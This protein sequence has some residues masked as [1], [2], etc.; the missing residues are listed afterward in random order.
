MEPVV[1]AEGLRHRYRRR[2]ALAATTLD[3]PA[4]RIAGFIGPDGV[5]KSTLLGLIAGAKRCQTGT[6]QVLGGSMKSARHRRKV[7]PRIA[8]MPQGLGKNLYADLTVRENIDFFAR[9][10]GHGRRE[11]SRRIGELLA[12]TG[13]EAFG[14]RPAGKLSGGMRQKLGLCCAL[15]HDPELLILDE[16]TTG[17]DPLSRRQFWQLIER[18]RAHRPEMTVLVATAYME[19]AER[20]DWLIAMDAGTVLATGTPAQLKAQTGTDTIEG[21][22]VALLPQSRGQRETLIVPPRRAA[23]HETAIAA[24]GLTR[25][26]GDFTAVDHVS[27]DIQRGEIFGFVGS[28]GCGKTTTM[29]MLTGLLPATAG[30]ATLF[31]K[32]IA[33]G[34]MRSRMRVGYMSQ[35]FSL[36]TELTVRQNLDLHARLFHL[37]AAS[38]AA[39]TEHLVR[40]FGLEDWCDQLAS[41]LP[42][43]IRQRLSLAVAVVHQPDVLILDE[44]TSGVDPLARDLFWRLLVDLS[45]NAGVTIFVSTHFMNEA[46][47]CDRVALMDSGRVLA[48]GKPQELMEARSAQTLDEAFVSYLEQAKGKTPVPTAPAL[49]ENAKHSRSTF[50]LRRAFAYAL[51][52]SLEL[53]RDPIRL[54]FALA[55]TAFL[56]LI[57]GFGITTDVDSLSF[58]VLDRDNSFESRAYLGEL[59]GSTYFIERPPIRD[60]NDLQERLKSGTANV[61]IEIPPGFGRDMKRGRPVAIS[62]WVDGSMPFRAE[63][64]HG[65]LEAAHRQFL[66]DPA[67]HGNGQ[68]ASPPVVEVSLR[69]RYNQDFSSVY[70]MVPAQL[71]LQ[72]ALIP[73]ILMALAI[74]REK[75]L[76][77]IVNLYVTPVTRLE[78]LLGK[79]IPYVAVAMTNFAIM[80]LMALFIFGVP[81]KGSFSALLTGALVYVL[82]TTAYGR[83]ISAFTRTQIAALFGTAIMTV[84]PATMFSGM[85]TPVS[86]LSGIAAFSGRFFPMTYFLPISLGTFTKG[87]GFGDLAGHLLVLSLFFPVLTLLSLLL[88][89]PQET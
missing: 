36:Y 56:M 68:A 27:F 6:L 22:F 25:R 70:A 48:T 39:R 52:E 53:L 13:L 58:A 74:V 42:L 28:N 63:T 46:G 5:G 43:G 88:M 34:G 84:L 35:S 38:I 85:L 24:R 65:Y 15:V 71:A 47:R 69:F 62:A 10:F 40:Q 30:T 77:S 80:Y 20:F 12:A 76:G 9:L 3:I 54:G 29:K 51:R 55:G 49:R 45:R 11:R 18:L 66:A 89:R 26:F 87:L 19:E 16:P 83:V 44:P 78:F 86:S 41:S 57:F 64:I 82:A 61:T 1:R 23:D 7:C 59:R 67:I 8:F 79:Q 60:A 50:S 31:G 14:D 32:P 17:V 2:D 33:A 72:L 37:P 21:A 75:E 4:G 73:A 81:L